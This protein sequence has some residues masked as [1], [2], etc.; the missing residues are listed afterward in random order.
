M[1]NH[2]DPDNKKISTMKKCG[3][4]GIERQTRGHVAKAN[5]CKD[6]FAVLT[7]S[8]RALWGR[9]PAVRKNKQKVDA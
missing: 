9:P 6:C 4:C 5:L 3:R 8:E 7:P 2:G 1:R